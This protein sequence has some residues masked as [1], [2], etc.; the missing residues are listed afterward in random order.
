[1]TLQEKMRVIEGRNTRGSGKPLYFLLSPND[2][3]EC[4]NILNVEREKNNVKPLNGYELITFN[5]LPV[6]EFHVVQDGKPVVVMG[7]E[8]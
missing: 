3:Q 7:D 5:G 2:F 8:E 4:R 6:F 1:V